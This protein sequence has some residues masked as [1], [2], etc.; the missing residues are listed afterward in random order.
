MTA[1]TSQLPAVADVLAA[2]P[3]ITPVVVIE[4]GQGVDRL[5]YG[6]QP[7]QYE[8][9]CL[10]PL[11]RH[12]GQPGPVHIGYGGAAF[13]GKSWWART[14]LTAVAFRWP[15]STG[16][17]FRETETEVK[18]NHLDRWLLEVPQLFEGRR[19]WSWNGQDKCITWFNGSKT[20]LG[21]L[22]YEKDVSRYQGPSFDVMIFEEATLLPWSAITWLT[23]TR[24]RGS[25]DGTVPFAGY[26]SNPGG[27][28]HASYK[29]LFIQRRFREE[30]QPHQYAF[31]QSLL[32][33]NIEGQQRD[34][35]YAGK[36]D[37]LPEPHRSWQRDGNFSAGA[38]SALEI[39]WRRH[40]VAPF[41]R[42][43]PDYW[44]RFGS[45]D[46]GYAHPFSFGSYAVNEDGTIYKLETVWGVRLK[47]Y[48]QAERIKATVPINRLRYI[49]AGHDVWA[50]RRAEGQ[51]TPSIADQFAAYDIHLTRANTDRI[52]GL[53]E[54]R[55]YLDWSVSGPIMDG[56]P[57]E[58]EPRLM[59]I[60]TAGNRR[61]LD[62][63]ENVVADPAD[64]RDVLKV[65]A[66]E[67]GEGGDDHYDETRYAVASRPLTPKG[68]WKDQ[69]I[70]A[71]APEVLAHE[72]DASRRVKRSKVP[73]PRVIPEAF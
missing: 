49:V 28:G 58:G 3:Y 65:D 1:A 48:L 7:K 50:E 37:L 69:P 31:V 72:A 67:F 34:P 26:P 23:S 27:Q 16:I 6:L 18:R 64:L 8:A 66:N 41:K 14:V 56:K 45:F 35:S 30:E 24:L 4:D 68:P 71:W 29:R 17:I 32:K 59:F 11:M 38:G 55:K 33:D 63:L 2:K 40:L 20:Y 42:G 9:F 15:G 52:Q 73:G 25:I 44:E 36:L 70:D 47:P 21:Y 19:L 61:C 51:D 53:E 46:W 60:D 10:T 22:Q 39:D 12:P 62:Q 54:M 43:I 57:T 13:G 5:L